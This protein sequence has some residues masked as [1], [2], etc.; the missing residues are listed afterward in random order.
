MN[1]QYTQEYYLFTNIVHE[2]FMHHFECLPL[3]VLLQHDMGEQDTGP[4]SVVSLRANGSL[5]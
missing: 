3:G 1:T 4:N 2:D 5:P